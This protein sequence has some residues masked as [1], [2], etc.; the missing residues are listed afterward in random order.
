MAS[1]V[2]ERCTGCGRCEKVCNFDA[3]AFDGPANDMVEK[4]YTIDTVSCEGCKVCVEFCP[5]DAIEF[6]D[7][8]NGRWFVSDT[9]F[10]P[11]VHAVLGTAQENSG[12]LVALIRKEAKKIGLTGKKT[13]SLW[14]ARPV[15]G[16]R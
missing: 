13:S 8:V 7:S 9:R 15:S 6:K 3:S 10:G 12:K 5:V 11:M 2:A 1:V 14:M 4:T 16:V